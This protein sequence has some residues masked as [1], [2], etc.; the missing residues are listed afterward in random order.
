MKYRVDQVEYYST[1]GRQNVNRADEQM[2]RFLNFQS[3][4]VFGLIEIEILKKSKK[5]QIHLEQIFQRK[6]GTRKGT[7]VSMASRIPS[8]MTQMKKRHTR[9]LSTLPTY[10]T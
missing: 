6:E 3:V 8:T 9:G 7:L 2:A 5:N 4:C 10:W 1:W